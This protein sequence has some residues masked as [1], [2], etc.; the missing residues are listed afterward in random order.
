MHVYISLNIK[1]QVVTSLQYWFTLYLS[2]EAFN[3]TAQQGLISHKDGA[4]CNSCRPITFQI[5]LVIIR[6]HQFFAI[7]TNLTASAVLET[8]RNQSC[9]ESIV[10][11]MEIKHN[12]KLVTNSSNFKP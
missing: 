10:M 8:G 1:K 3:Y 12:F 11:E 6:A 4:E 2:I 9:F 5:F 7:S